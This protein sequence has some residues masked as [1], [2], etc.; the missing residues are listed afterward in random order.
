[1]TNRVGATGTLAQSGQATSAPPRRPSRPASVAEVRT[2]AA[3]AVRDRRSAPVGR[4]VDDLAAF[5]EGEWS[6]T[7][8]LVPV[9]GTGAGSFE[10]TAT[11]ARTAT[12]GELLYEEHGTARLGDHVGSAMRRL[13]FEVQGPRA[14]VRFDDGRYFH[15]LDLREGSWHADHPC[16]EDLYCGRFTVTGSAAW[17]QHWTVTGPTEAYHLRTRLVRRIRLPD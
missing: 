3:A 17:E 4:G 1:M 7:R 10:G 13:R 9:R 6:V 15:D 8:E 2:P 5:L 12:P 16:G 14:V 11:V